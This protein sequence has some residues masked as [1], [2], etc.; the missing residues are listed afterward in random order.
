M[1]YLLKLLAKTYQVIPKE[2]ASILMSMIK[3]NF[4]IIM[5]EN[6]ISVRN[7]L[8]ALFG[9]DSL[10]IA[11][12]LDLLIKHNL[13]SIFGLSLENP[14]DFYFLNWM[15]SI[16]QNK[17]NETPGWSRPLLKNITPI[18][19][20]TLILIFVNEKHP[21]ISLNKIASWCFS[22]PIAKSTL[23][24][25]DET[26]RRFIIYGNKLPICK[27]FP[28]QTLFLEIYHLE[29]SAKQNELV[30]NDLSQEKLVSTQGL[31]SPKVNIESEQKISNTVAVSLNAQ[32][33]LKCT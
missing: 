5:D 24:L 26:I 28:L 15:N 18:Q 19:F 1:T 33:G 29:K 8:T 21:K 20:L 9:K 3:K 31:Y 25:F 11:G 13:V 6:N 12:L 30:L 10:R 7:A 14:I 17:E 22:P 4:E 16:F 23:A 32:S 27:Y 2:Q